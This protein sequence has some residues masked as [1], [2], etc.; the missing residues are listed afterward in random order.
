MILIECCF[1]EV[2]DF[3]M[4]NHETW[5]QKRL[6][7]NLK[8]VD[9]FIMCTQMIKQKYTECISSELKNILIKYLIYI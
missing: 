6:T 3:I 5:M 4:K 1:T 2:G 7:I 8:V 9:S